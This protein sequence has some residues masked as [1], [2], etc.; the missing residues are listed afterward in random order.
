MSQREGELR[1]YQSI[2]H[3]SLTDEANLLYHSPALVSFP[4]TA[5]QLISVLKN[6]YH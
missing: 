2:I 1:K 5:L 4:F 3:I 6:K